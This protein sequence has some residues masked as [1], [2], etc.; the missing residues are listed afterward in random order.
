[1]SVVNCSRDEVVECSG[2]KSSWSRAAR[3][4]LLMDG[5]IRFSRTFAAME[6]SGIGRYEVPWVVSLS[7]FGNGMINDDFHI[8]GIWHALTEM[9][10]RA[11]VYSIALGPRCFKWKMLSLSAK[12]LTVS[13]ALITRSSV[14]VCVIFV[15]FLFVSLVT[16]WISLE[17]VWL[18]RFDALNCWLN[19]MAS[20]LEDENDLSLTNSKSCSLEN[21]H[22]VHIRYKHTT[23]A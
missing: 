22:K 8:D 12:C 5:R 10:K 18:P 14:N 21:C 23:S 9:L 15:D 7:G 4:Y 1:M 13:I 16:N 6:K 20:Y 11:V 19:M 17:E 2:L 3:R